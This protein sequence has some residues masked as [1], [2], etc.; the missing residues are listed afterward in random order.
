MAQRATD[1]QATRSELQRKRE[2]GS[3]TRRKRFDQDW[4]KVEKDQKRKTM[5]KE[6]GIQIK[7]SHDENPCQK[8]MENS[9]PKRKWIPC[10]VRGKLVIFSFTHVISFPA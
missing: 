8:T 3:D 9:I 5:D 10:K 6:K 4:E 1:R 2:K 7:A